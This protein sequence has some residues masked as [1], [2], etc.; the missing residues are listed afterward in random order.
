MKR[1]M[2]V[3]GH[4]RGLSNMACQKMGR[5]DG[6]AFAAVWDRDD[7][8]PDKTPADTA[9]L[10]ASAAVEV[11]GY[12]TVLDCMKAKNAYFERHR[13]FQAGCH[14][15]RQGYDSFCMFHIMKRSWLLLKDYQRKHGVEYDVAI[16][17]RPDYVFS[18]LPPDF[19]PEPG[20]VYFPTNCAF[21]DVTDNL[22]LAEFGTMERMMTLPDLVDTYLLVEKAEWTHEHLID[23]HLKAAGLKRAKIPGWTYASADG[24][25]AGYNPTPAPV[26]NHDK[27]IATILAR[28][29]EDIVGDCIRHHLDN[30]VDEIIFMD[31]GSMDRTREIAAGFSRVTVVD[32]PSNEYRQGEWQSRMAEMAM[33]RG[34]TWVIPIDADEFW[35]GID[36]LR[37]I[38]KQFGVALASCLYNHNHTDLIEEPFARAMMPCYSR[39]DRKFGVWISGR[40]AFRPYRGVRIAMGQDNIQDYK[41]TIGVLNEMWLHHYP[42][43]SY[44]RYARKI[45]TGVKALNAGG[46]E[47]HAGS[48]WRTAYRHLM[49]GTLKQEYDKTKTYL[50]GRKTAWETT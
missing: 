23:H 6:D 8:T 28:N 10:A 20:T 48:H 45:E 9:S 3:S 26:G 32:E 39:L 36:N 11:V 1:A 42:I 33:D 50:K 24:K 44:E 34:A 31:N 47:L 43:R 4:L 22:F 7:C 16:R 30:G 5:F 40:F 12:E 41:G 46:H 29:E 14:K 15:G 35:E 25:P 49:A 17:F 2:F 27:I 21:M 13:T 38:P 18:G 19:H 37:L